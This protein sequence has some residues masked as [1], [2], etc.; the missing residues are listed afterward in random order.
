MMSFMD[1]LIKILYLV[2]CLDRN[3]LFVTSTKLVC[4]LNLIFIF[5]SVGT[6][7]ISTGSFSMESR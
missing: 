2:S 5:F 7:P 4:S 6:E 1:F 3:M